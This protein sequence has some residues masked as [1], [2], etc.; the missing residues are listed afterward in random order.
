MNLAGIL[1]GVRFTIRHPDT[2]KPLSFGKVYTYED[3]SLIPKD[4]W[5]DENK[6]AINTNPI[7]LDASGQCDL[8]LD[9]VYRIVVKDNNDLI[10]NTIDR[11]R[12]GATVAREFAEELING[13]TQLNLDPTILNPVAENINS[14]ITAVDNIDSIV[15]DALNIEAIKTNALNINSINTNATNI[16]TIQTASANAIIAEQQAQIATTKASESLVN[17][18]NALTYRNEA[19]IFKT[20]AKSS[21]INAD[22]RATAASTSEINAK[23]SEL[24]ALQY[25]DTT[26]SLKEETLLL[27]NETV[28]NAMTATEQATI[29]TTKAIIAQEQAQLAT[30]KANESSASA[31]SA[32]TYKNEALVSATTASTKATE[33]S[34]SATESSTSATNAKASE[35]LALQY[36]NTTQSLK[37]ETILLKDSAASS[38]TTATQQATISTNKAVEAST[39]ATNAS[40][41]EALAY[42][43]ANELENA[44]VLNGEYSAYHWASKTEET[45]NNITID[46][47]KNVDVTGIVDGSL[48]RYDQTLNQWVDYNFNANPVIGFDTTASITVNKGQLSWNGTEGTLDLGLDNGSTLQ[49]G[50]ENIRLVRN[51]TATTITNGTVVMSNGSIGN[52]GRIRVIPYT[53]TTGSHHLIYGIA[54]QD[55]LPNSDG[56]ITIDGKVR[57]INTTGISVGETWLDGDVL[58]VKPNNNGKLTKVEPVGLDIKMPIATVVH[59]HTSGVLEVRILPIDENQSYSKTESDTI[60]TPLNGTGATGTWG[61]N[62]SGNSSAA[63]TLTGLTATI[64]ELNY[65][66]GVTSNIQTQLNNKASNDIVTT[67]T[68]GL[69]ASTDKVKLNSL[70]NYTLPNA[71]ATT[72]GGIKVGSNLSIDANGVLNAL[73]ASSISWTNITDKPT[74]ISGYGITDAYTK[75][76]VG[77]LAEFT[78]NLG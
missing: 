12:D 11:V 17:A 44:I 26:L 34:T 22:L 42:K 73:A 65:N 57:G 10:I 37:D 70:E 41:S 68:N 54:T 15:I 30:T 66:G 29:S 46:T 71:S 33:S 47:L 58:Y 40:N 1:T 63:T 50:Q 8:F 19:E 3:N 2:D 28:S 62:I 31:T 18:N 77:T 23:T 60:F 5:K 14:I 25:K 39:S 55:I 16:A 72:L 53:A 69:M 75:T 38:A 59:S 36:K 21:E 48:L 7:I 67:T 78:T 9:G 52:S 13:Y 4:T 43:W 76:E 64:A 27:K 49:V 74:T 20:N 6:K 35:L 24:L 45:I 51:N 61:I 32:L 56:I